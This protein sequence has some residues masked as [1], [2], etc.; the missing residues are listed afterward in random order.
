MDVQNDVHST[1]LFDTKVNNS[2]LNAQPES[3]LGLC[4]IFDHPSLITSPISSDRYEECSFLGFGLMHLT[5]TGD[6]VSQQYQSSRKLTM[7]RSKSKFSSGFI[8]KF[9]I[10]S[11]FSNGKNLGSTTIHY[12]QFFS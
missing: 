1:D 9:T 11:H 5:R 8:T 12:A 3:I 2:Y 7:N 4:I 10:P 6:L